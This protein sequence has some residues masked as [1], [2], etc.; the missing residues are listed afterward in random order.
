MSVVGGLEAAL[1]H[2]PL[3]M[4]VEEAAEVLRVSRAHGYQLARRYEASDGTEGI[5]VLRVGNCLR[6]P[7]W[8]LVELLGTGRLVKLRDAIEPD[9]P[10]DDVLNEMGTTGRPQRRQRRHTVQLALLP[11]D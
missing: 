3:M 9:E 1:A 4:T 6:V 5:P 2:Y 11:K 7:R 10:L 8:A